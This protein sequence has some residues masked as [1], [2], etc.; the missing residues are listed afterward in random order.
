MARPVSDMLTE[1]EARI[2]AVLWKLGEASSGEVREQLTDSLHDS[3]VR[4]MLR[5]LKK[6][7]YVRTKTNVRP[8]IYL[9]AVGESDV[10]K[11]AARSLLGRFFGGS[12]EALVLRLIEDEQLTPKQLDQLKQAHQPRRK[13]RKSGGKS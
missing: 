9:P 3:T 12:A 13:G 8:T 5:V 10:Q 2:M 1:R 11:K 6:K 4:T 7:G